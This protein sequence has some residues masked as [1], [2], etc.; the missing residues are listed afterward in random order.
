[1]SGVTSLNLFVSSPGD[2]QKERERVDFIVERLNAEYMDRVQIRA[3]R[4]ETRYYSSH[5]TFQARAIVIWFWE[6]SARGS[7]RRCRKAFR[8]CPRATRIP[9]EPL[10]RC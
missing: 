3:I 2:V 4:W 9:A 5:D 7:D 10:M 1:M 6:Y 8:T